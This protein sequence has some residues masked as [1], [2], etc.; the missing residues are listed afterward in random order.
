MNK[1]NSNKPKSSKLVKAEAREKRL[2]EQLRA[3]L[4]RRKAQERTRNKDTTRNE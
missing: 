1:N 3:N 2:K 4:K